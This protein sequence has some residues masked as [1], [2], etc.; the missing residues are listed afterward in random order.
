MNKVAICVLWG[1]VSGSNEQNCTI[2]LI[3][4]VWLDF[5]WIYAHWW[6]F[7]S[8]IKII[9]YS[10]KRGLLI[11]RKWCGWLQVVGSCP[12][13]EPYQLCGRIYR[14]FLWI[15]DLLAYWI[16]V[17]GFI[18]VWHSLASRLTRQRSLS[19]AFH[20]C[21]ALTAFLC[22]LYVCACLCQLKRM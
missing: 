21:V 3:D 22:N 5:W 17:I 2:V 12:N 15:N 11:G 6:T 19:C 20:L 10:D 18:D 4:E 13:S 8:R 1:F 7:S 16:V 14:H 9:Y